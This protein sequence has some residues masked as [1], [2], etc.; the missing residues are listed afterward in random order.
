MSDIPSRRDF[1]KTGLAT[2]AA[3]VIGAKLARADN[4]SELF[5]KTW[6]GS[7][8]LPNRA[9]KS[10]TWSGMGDQKGRV[11][12][13]VLEFY[14]ELARGDIGLILTGYQY[15][16][17]NGQHMPY[18]VGNYDDTLTEGLRKIADTVHKEGGKVV[19]QLVHC[20]ARANPKMFFNDGDELWGASAIAYSPG[21]PIPKEM[22]R[23]DIVRLV[24]AHAAAASR[25]KRCGFDGIQIHGAH[26]YGINQF[27]SPA[28]N[29][30]SDSYGG[31]VANRYRVVG[32]IIEAMRGVVGKDYPILFKLS[33]QDFVA[34]GL[35]PPES[36]EIARRLASDG[37]AGIQVSACS[38]I[39]VK[40]RHCLKKEIHEEKDEGY[41]VDFAQYIKEGVKVPIIAVGGI[42]SLSTVDEI[43]KV[44]KADYISMARPFIREPHLIKR[45]KSG[46]TSRAT[47]ISCNRCFEPGMKGEGISCYW[48][49]IKKEPRNT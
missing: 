31:S 35:E 12:D 36:L 15:V 18:M 5:E 9:I 20:M 6:I 21:D 48:E 22:S 29:R 8:E 1:L 28:W 34:N 26:G 45:W 39:S 19:A 44:R 13:R 32:E 27:L 37:I 14:G 40:D 25:S 3:V 24:E 10:S 4:H 38:T 11:T 23:K 17:T 46:D 7:L 30:R 41:L 16:M 33:A 49:R 47:C 42:R 2:A 43:L